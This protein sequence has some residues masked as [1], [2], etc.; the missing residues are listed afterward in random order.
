MHDVYAIINLNL[1][2]AA[3]LCR[4]QMRM[5]SENHMSTVAIVPYHILYQI[6]NRGS[7]Y[8]YRTPLLNPFS[9]TRSC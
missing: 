2:Y 1:F 7:L 8:E 6:S 5:P 4:F 3:L 9:T